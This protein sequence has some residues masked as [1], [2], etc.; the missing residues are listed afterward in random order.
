MKKPSARNHNCTTKTVVV[1]AGCRSTANNANPLASLQMV[2]IAVHTLNHQR[3]LGVWTSPT[4]DRWSIVPSGTTIASPVGEQELDFGPST[5][6][7]GLRRTRCCDSSR[8]A[9]TLEG[10]LTGRRDGTTIPW[11]RRGD[12]N[13]HALAG[14]SSLGWRVCLF[15]HSDVAID[16]LR[17]VNCG[18]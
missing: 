7:N 10:H 4:S 3:I 12:L 1:F 13:P 5:G 18:T 11:C 2:E 14:T 16:I 6:T 9:P 17:D 15:R 8:T